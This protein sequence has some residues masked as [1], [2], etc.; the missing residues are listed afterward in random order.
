M[1]GGVMPPPGL[2][3]GMFG[4]GNWQDEIVGPSPDK[5]GVHGPDVTQDIFGPVIQYVSC[6]KIFGANFGAMAVVPIANVAFDFPR[7][8]VDTSS[9]L[10]LSQL[11]IVPIMLGWHH[12]DP[13]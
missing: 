4:A 10:D 2:Y 6:Y 9:G 1:N 12:T 3:A 8:D 11:W 7:L 13:M 5:I